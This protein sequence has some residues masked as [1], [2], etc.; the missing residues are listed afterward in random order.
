MRLVLLA[1]LLLAGCNAQPNAANL[2]A[3]LARLASVAIND[4]NVAAADAA[5]HGDT[6]AAACYP[7]LANWIIT[8]QQSQGQ[9]TAPAGAFSAFQ[10]TRDILKSGMPGIPPSVK[11]GCAALYLD[12]QGD[13]LK[14]VTL[15]ASISSG[16]FIPP[17]P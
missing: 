8:L 1:C 17:L 2:N 10:Q 15:L 7:A 12:A 5:N 4:L 9:I 16:Q 13:V 3:Q 14:F 6:L 11:L